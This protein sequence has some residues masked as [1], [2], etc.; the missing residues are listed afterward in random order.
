MSELA[1]QDLR[2]QWAMSQMGKLSLK[3]EKA[4]ALYL[5]FTGSFLGTGYVLGTG[6][7]RHGF[8]LIL[9]RGSDRYIEH[10]NTG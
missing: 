8:I 10:L 9:G 7:G 3:E 6:E 1:G 5:L 4:R 2:A